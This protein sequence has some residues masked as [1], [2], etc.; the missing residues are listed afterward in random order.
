MDTES[1]Y[2]ERMKEEVALLFSDDDSYC[3]SLLPP[4]AYDT[5]WVA[6]IGSGGGAARPL[7][8]QC[9]EWILANQRKEGFWGDGERALDSVAATIVSVLA[10]HQWNTGRASIE[11]GLQYLRANI[12]KILVQCHGGIPRW[13]TI[14]F[15]GLLELTQSKGLRVLR[16]HDVMQLVNDVFKRRRTILTAIF[17]TRRFNHCWSLFNGRSSGSDQYY[18]PLTMFL[19]ALPPSSRPKHELI[20]AQLMEDGS[21]FRSPSATAAAFMITGDAN[22]LKYLQ[23]MMQ[24][25]SGIVPPVF[26]VDQN[27]IRLC[28]VDHLSRLG[29]GQFFEE[30]IK[31]LLDHNYRN[32]IKQHQEQSTT[33]CVLSEQIY[34]DTLAFYLLRTYG[35]PVTPRKLCW[36]MDN[37]GILVH[38]R[39]NHSEFLGAM[40]GIYRAAQ[41]MF[42]E[43]VDLHNTKLFSL[44]VLTKCLPRKDFEGNDKV[45]T[46]FQKEIARELELPWLLRMDHLEHR[47]Y[48][49]RTKGYWLCIG[50]TNICR[51]SHP[52][53]L[54][55]LAVDNF[56]KRQSIYRN[57]LQMLKRWSEESGLSKMG[58]GREKTTYCY[59]LATVP[60]CLPLHC[61]LRKIVAKNATLVTIADD[62][63]DEKGT[64]SE[65]ETLTEAVNRWEGDNLCS[66][67]K[68]IFDALHEL[69]NEV[70]FNAFREHDKTV[71]DALQEMWRD[72]F[73]SWLKESKWSR[74]KH[75]PST[76]EYIDVATVSVAIQV[77]T[78]PAC[79]ITH[80]KVP[81]DGKLGSRYCKMT[82]LS[83]LCA[84][85]LNDIGSYM[86]ELE[87]GKFNMVPLY[88]KENLESSIE[89]SVGHI[90]TVLERKG[91]EFLELFL[92]Q[93]YGGVPRVWKEL[94]VA[95]LKAFW[96]LYDSNN[97]F[98]SPTALLQ[99]I[100]MA[101][102]E[103]LAIDA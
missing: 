65:L 73:N 12:E 99:A 39:E 54:M 58:F 21:L 98:D 46:D 85:L 95:T 23:D 61:E 84:R 80:P 31:D 81:V 101:F 17:Q 14:V 22:C 40:Y 28:L 25:C 72:A 30:E 103:P 94:H 32:W 51:L 90:K 87:D 13:F 45:M 19:E 42:P 5:A 70:E 76:D 59:F 91:K 62:F 92:N 15:P 52:K 86:R 24:R 1:Y 47:L 44:E 38:I 102:Y 69:V 64:E 63:F 37:K 33:N 29:C 6:M 74:C 20:L 83:M 7:F 26:P 9:V 27:L 77:M 41:L 49:E 55:Q 78:L 35:Y 56:T 48:I 16:G 50:K 82:E 57:E 43:E 4:S 8:P 79:Y 96:M 100:R 88:V 11:R 60:T 67:S 66:H 75:V 68:V 18:P 34:S 93:E 97:K 2:T 71:K 36:F 89:D 53:C 3:C 10:L